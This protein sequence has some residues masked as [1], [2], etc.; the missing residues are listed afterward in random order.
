MNGSARG[1]N[2]SIVRNAGYLVGA[3]VVSRTLRV[4]YTV[5]LARLF[6]PEL[7]GLFTYAQFWQVIFMSLATFG[8]GRML[9]RQ[10]GVD[11]SQAERHVAVN[12][13][14][15]LLTSCIAMLGCA[16][17]ALDPSLSPQGRDLMLLFAAALLARSVAA[18]AQQVF[19]AFEV[20]HLSLRQELL[21]RSFEVI[22]GLGV[23]ALG[24]GLVAVAVVHVLSWLLQAA[25]GWR[26]VNRRIVPVRFEWRMTELLRLAHN[27]MAIML[28]GFS[29]A[30]LIQGGL[31]MYRMLLDEPADL[32]QLAILLQVL[33]LLAMVPKSV[34]AA[35]LPVLSRWVAEG[36]GD[37]RR[38]MTLMLRTAIIGA[39]GLAAL[40][41]VLGPILIPWLVGE[42]Y[43]AAG[44]LIPL[45]LWLLLPLSLCTLMNQ[46]MTARGEFW[47]AAMVALSAA[48][49]MGF[50]I[51]LTLPGLGL[52]AVFLGIAA[53]ATLWAM[54]EGGFAVRAGWLDGFDAF[55][56]PGLAVVVAAVA[57][58]LLGGI[59]SWMALFT[60]WLLLLPGLASPRV[61]W[62]RVQGVR[63]V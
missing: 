19:T 57:F 1:G 16:L 14:L 22:V 46:L 39:A 58:W 56:R 32:G 29:L 27:G 12:I 25:V 43:R 33:G 9:S 2:H 59:S 35:A 54:V 4:I 53:G 49:C 18:W 62:R 40:A 8:T 41:S 42:Q 63:R 11:R 31:L 3:K 30:A 10:I 6:G 15:R 50:V 23:L 48:V 26:L 38:S 28:V 52:N 34:A 51:T 47:R 13:S 24:G 17:V 37:E 5:V 21:F 45:A 44:E 7:F 61:I 60:S 55:G 36:A 20:S